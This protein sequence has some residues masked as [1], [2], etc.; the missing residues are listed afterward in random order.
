MTGT[1]LAIA[2]M[3]GETAPILFTSTLFLNATSSDRSDAARDG[4]VQDLRRT[5]EQP[6]PN[7]HE[8]AWAAA[9]VLIMFVLVISLSARYFLSRSQ[10]KLTGAGRPPSMLSRVFARA[11]SG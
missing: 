9:F 7:L 11:R 1:T 10:R 8:Q 3:A 4:A 6:D 5:R 2:R